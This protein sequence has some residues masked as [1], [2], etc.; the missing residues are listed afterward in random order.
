MNTLTFDQKPIVTI[1]L[2]TFNRAKYLQRCIE[3]VLAQTYKD[4]ELLVVDDGSKD[5]TFQVVDAYLQQYPNI[6]Y[7]KHKNKK[8]SLSR[9]VGIMASFGAYITFIDSDD[10]YKPNHIQTRL[11]YMLQHPEVDMI[12]GG[13]E[14]EE[15]VFLADYYRP[16]ELINIRDC[17]VGPTFFGKRDVYFKM[18]G[19][20]I[21]YYGEDAEFWARTEKVFNLVK[22][23]GPETYM[24]SRADDSITKIETDKI[25]H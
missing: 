22:L 20:N 25:N 21:I 4:W 16:G 23:T 5:E 12:E 19:F 17:V 9:N 3:S 18:G 11:D 24:Y 8:L 14:L 10:A 15:E 13:I 1:V 6:R 2:C 7:M